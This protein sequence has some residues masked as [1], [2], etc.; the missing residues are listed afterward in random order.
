MLVSIARE[1][2]EA[3]PD[4]I[5]RLVATVEDK[6]PDNLKLIAAVL[7]WIKRLDVGLVQESNVSCRQRITK[8]SIL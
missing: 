6:H 7:R 5:Q 3:D 2:P 4:A 1:V 8:R